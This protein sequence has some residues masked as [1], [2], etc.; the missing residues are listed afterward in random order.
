M[1]EAALREVGAARSI[2]VDEDGVILA[3]NATVEAAAAAG[4]ERVLTVDADGETIVAVRRSGLTPEQK[5][6]LALYDNRAAELADWDASV[7]EG[8]AAEVDLSGLFFDDELDRLL[9]RLADFDPAAE[10]GGMPA[11]HQDDQMPVKQLLV[12][13]ASAEDVQSFAALVGQSITM[14]TKSVWCPPRAIE[15]KD[16]AYLGADDAT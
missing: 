13:F 4:I 9:G 1:I 15:R 10:W 3:G 6:K 2:V 5:T 16:Q 8:L 14:A 7:L 12:N 11:F